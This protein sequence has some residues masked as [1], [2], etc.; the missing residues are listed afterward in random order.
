M[1]GHQGFLVLELGWRRPEGCQPELLA[2]G[3]A[4]RDDS[5]LFSYAPG[6]WGPK[7]ANALIEKDGRHWFL[8][9]D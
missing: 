8:D 7:E 2:G 9:E 4:R 6:S 1:L 3:S 5:S